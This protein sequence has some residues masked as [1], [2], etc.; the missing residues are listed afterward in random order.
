MRS[1]RRCARNIFNHRS[2]RPKLFERRLRTRCC[3]QFCHRH[4]SANNTCAQHSLHVVVAQPST[5]PV[6]SGPMS[7]NEC[8]Q[9]A[10]EEATSLFHAR[11]EIAQPP[12]PVPVDGLYVLIT[13][14]GEQWVLEH[15]LD[16]PDG[17]M[18]PP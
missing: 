6:Q 5:E 2:R 15:L 16:D 13:E 17:C 12:I 11:N 1:L 14:T 18:Q 4:C 7:R 8:K 3:S 9:H 10:C